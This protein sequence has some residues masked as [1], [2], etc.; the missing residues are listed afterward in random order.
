MKKIN[1]PLVVMPENRDDTTHKD[2]RLVNAFVDKVG[3]QLWVTKRPGIT[4]YSLLPDG[5]VQTPVI[6]LGCAFYKSSVFAIWNSSPGPGNGGHLYKD[7]V[8]ASTTVMDTT[9]R[10]SFTPY[11]GASPGLFMKNNSA[12]YY[13]DN[14]LG[15]LTQVTNV[16]NNNFNYVI[17]DGTHL[18]V[19]GDSGTIKTATS[20]SHDMWTS[21]SSGV[22]SNLN[23]I[24][25]A[26]SLYI[27]VGDGGVILKSSD[28]ITWSP[29]T[30]GVS[31]KLNSVAGKASLFVAVGDGGVVLK[32]TD[33]TTWTVA[34]S[35][36]THD[37]RGVDWDGTYFA[38]CGD[39]GTIIYSTNASTWAS[40]PS[41][42]TVRLNAIMSYGLN[43]CIV[44]NAGAIV[45]G[46]VS[47]G[48]TTQ[49]SGTTNDLYGGF[50]YSSTAFVVVGDKG[51]ILYSNT[52]GSSW[53]AGSSGTLNKLASG[54]SLTTVYVVVG[55]GGTTLSEPTLTGPWSPQYNPVVSI[56]PATT[57]G[58][59]VYLDGTIYVMDANSNIQGSA[60]NT[61]SSWDAVNL[62]VAN[63]IPDD[64]VAIVGQI[65]YIIAM[66][67]TSTQVFYDAGQPQ[68]SPLGTV[69]GELSQIGCKHPSLIQYID[70]TILWVSTSRNGGVNVHAMEGLKPAIVSTSAIDRILEGWDYTNVYSW[71]T[72]IAGRKLYAITSVVSN[73]TLVFDL[74]TK[75][76]SQ[77]TT[78]DSDSYI[79]M[80]A[81]CT[82]Q[83]GDAILQHENNGA[84]YVL[85]PSSYRDD[86]SYFTVHIYTPSVDF[87]TRGRKFVNTLDIVADKYYGGSILVSV[88]D[89]DY[90][91]WS[92]P[93]NVDMGLSRPV[94]NNC[95]TFRRRAWHI[96]HRANTPLR[97][98]SLEASIDLGVI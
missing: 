59:V 8:L 17:S 24:C 15:T 45:I 1:I 37:L 50:V 77:W 52:S 29:V 70:G 61:P 26:N 18:V 28:M 19:V 53:T 98:K 64:P 11:L 89:D 81:A 55:I 66:K 7:N 14:R 63:S 91:S 22:T 12:A 76:W 36:T 86:N 58:G 13:Y 33:G 73:M 34:T 56:Y 79:P 16:A 74:S 95:G 68:G 88:S 93:R 44:G 39:I 30:S 49:T 40:K 87:G 71:T 65:S 69:Q 20:A 42:T 80:V 23:G 38:A 83:N 35:G 2:A 97:I 90:Q 84:M 5:V 57:V 41:G 82:N 21:R 46:S 43:Q 60:I 32:S 72:K 94:L 51:T 4:T 54:A 10:Y 9:S 27:A 75:I 47:G 96:S 92:E 62:I 6:A 78:T 31:T 25:Y 48:F 3:E 85:D 67:N